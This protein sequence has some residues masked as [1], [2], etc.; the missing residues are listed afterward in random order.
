MSFDEQEDYS[1]DHTEQQCFLFIW[2]LFFH[3]I[4]ATFTVCWYMT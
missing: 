2:S 4:M 3:M 1:D